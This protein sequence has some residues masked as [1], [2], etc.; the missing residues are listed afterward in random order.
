MT[1][2]F[3]PFTSNI[4]LFRNLSSALLTGSAEFLSWQIDSTQAFITRS[5]Q[6]LKAALSDLGS[7]QEPEQ[8]PETMQNGLLKA[9]KLSQDFLLASTEYQMESLR[10]LQAQSTETQKAIAEALNE[11]FAMVDA[12]VQG[13]KSQPHKRR[14]VA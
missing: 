14:L 6:Q 11:Q 8:W 1:P 5:S 4:N 13:D 3:A 9:L 12:S 2:Q 10:L 7:V